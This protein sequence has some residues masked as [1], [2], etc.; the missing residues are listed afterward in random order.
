LFKRNHT[1]LIYELGSPGPVAPFKFLDH[2]PPILEESFSVFA[3]HFTLFTVRLTFLQHCIT[4]TNHSSPHGHRVQAHTVGCVLA[5]YATFCSCPVNCLVPAQALGKRG[6]SFP[7]WKVL[8]TG[9]MTSDTRKTCG[10]VDLPGDV[11]AFC[12]NI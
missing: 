1:A 10:T 12:C 9:R 11:V 5:L 2:F 4:Q 7:V 6:L 8:A 3:L